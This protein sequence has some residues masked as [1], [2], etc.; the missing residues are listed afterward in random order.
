MANPGK[1]LISYKADGVI[2]REARAPSFPVAPLP[3]RRPKNLYDGRTVLSATS[4]SAR[5]TPPV[6]DKDSSVGA[7]ALEREDGF[8]RRLPQPQRVLRNLAS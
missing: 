1:Y 8:A 3:V 6:S 7:Q 5:R 2:L 4:A